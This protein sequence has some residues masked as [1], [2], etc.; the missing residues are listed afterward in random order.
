MA[1]NQ[2]DVLRGT[3]DL[4]VLK[5]LTLEPMHG[6]GI[7]A[8]IQQFS[9]GTLD[10]NQGSLYPALQRLEQRGWIESDWQTTENNRRAKYYQLT[11]SGRRARRRRDG[12]LAPLRRG[13]RA[14][15][16][17]RIGN[18]PWE[19]SPGFRA[20][21]RALLNPRGADRDLTDEIRFHIEL[22]TEKN[23]RLGMSADDARRVAVAH[24]GGVQRVREEHHDVRRPHWIEDFVGDARFAVRSLRRT[25]GLAAAAIVT[26]ALGIGANA[27]IFSAVNAVVLQPLPMPHSNRLDD[28]LGGEPGE[29]LAQTDRRAGQLPRL[30]RAGAGLSGRGGVWRFPR[31]GHAYRHGRST[32][33]P[34]HA[35]DGKFLLHCRRAPLL[36]RALT[37]DET[38]IDRH[39]RGR[40]ELSRDGA[41][42]S[43]GTRP[44]SARRFDS[45][46]RTCRSWA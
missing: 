24:F 40:A 2:S 14:D 30:A 35:R 25:P 11:A 10:V 36:G 27:A 28:A 31:T 17:H 9:R 16:R 26:L 1:T 29:E 32:F 21:L 44:S 42:S 34:S 22:E 5:T 41:T 4:L 20:R 7:S 33:A 43:D 39:R 18:R 46:A 8:R 45:M 19:S 13:G 23:R 37:D 15:P 6:W 38:W 12:E 3:L